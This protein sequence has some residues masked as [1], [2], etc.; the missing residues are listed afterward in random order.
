M[1]QIANLLL[2][3]PE[4]QEAILNR[5]RFAL[6]GD[7][8]TGHGLRSLVDHTNWNHQEQLWNNLQSLPSE[9]PESLPRHG[10]PA[11]R[12]ATGDRSQN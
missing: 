10:D 6:S 11:A 3:A 4:I 8:I 9:V 12:S 5:P 1:T 2:L 7:T